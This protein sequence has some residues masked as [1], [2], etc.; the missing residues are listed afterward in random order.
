MVL[1]HPGG[2]SAARRWPVANWAQVATALAADGHRVGISA[3]PREEALAASVGQPVWSGRD[4][5]DLAAL[6]AGSRLVL[7]ADTGVAH[8]ATALRRPS[9]V[10]FGP[11]SPAIWG[12]P[13]GRP[14]HR[15]LWK[16]RTGDPWASAPDPGL[17]EIAPRD[18]VA[19]AASRV[20]HRPGCPG[21][22]WSSRR[23]RHV[24]LSGVGAGGPS[25]MVG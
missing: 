18:V 17:L 4:V 23:P 15:V 9:V 2:S 21:R 6:V 7:S 24:R 20:R 22:A 13:P 10:L 25:F 11:T 8:L 5:L 12:P 1:V 14:W 16:G 19:A 3:G